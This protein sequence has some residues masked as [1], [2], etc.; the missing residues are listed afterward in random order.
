M[1]GAEVPREL[2]ERVNRGRI[3]RMADDRMK[4]MARSPGKWSSA[5]VNS[6]NWLFRM[7]SRTGLMTRMRLTAAT[8]RGVW[9]RKRNTE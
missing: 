5:A 2:E 1:A 7:R 9:T 3:R 6:G 4:V 8:A